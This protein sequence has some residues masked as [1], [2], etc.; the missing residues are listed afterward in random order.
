MYYM[1]TTTINYPRE[2]VSPILILDIID[3]LLRS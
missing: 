2:I 1:N 3:G